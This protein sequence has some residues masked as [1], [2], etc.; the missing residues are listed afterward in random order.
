M[1]LHQVGDGGGLGLQF[2]AED[3]M[4]YKLKIEQMFVDLCLDCGTVVRFFV[5]E[6]KRK[7]IKR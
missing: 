3:T 6:P 1:D 4:F 2:E 7:W 5:K